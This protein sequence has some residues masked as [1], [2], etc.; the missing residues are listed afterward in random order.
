MAG[1]G[2]DLSLRMS[3]EEQ[4]IDG[5]LNYELIFSYFKRLKVKISHAIEKTFPFL[6]LLRDHEFITN[7]MFEDCETSCRNLV[8]INNV[9]YNVLDELEKKFNLEVLKIL[10]N[11][12]NIKEYPGLTPIYEIFLN[13]LPKK[14][15][16]Q[17]IDE[18]GREE[19]PS[20]Q[21]SLEQGSGENSFPSLPG[22]QSD[23]SFSTGTTPPES[24]LLEHLCETE[25]ANARRN[26]TTGDK[27][28]A[29]GGQQANQQC[30]PKP[31][32]AGS[33]LSSQG[34]QMNS[35]FV[36]LVNIMKEIPLFHSEDEQQAQARTNHNQASYTIGINCGDSGKP[37]D[38]HEPPGPSISALEGGHESSK[39]EKAQEATCSRPQTAPDTMD[40]GNNSALEEHNG[41]RKRK[42][43]IPG[44]LKRRSSR[45]GR[46]RGTSEKCIKRDNGR[47]FTLKR[48][49]IKGGY[50][51]SSKWKQNIRCGG[52]PLQDLIEKGY[53]QIPP[54]AEKK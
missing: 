47:W 11:E 41:K 14:W 21:L 10:F 46:R 44:P 24:G 27:N 39:R 40:A 12:D 15:Y 50:K 17:E 36:P 43:A 53:L 5:R 2:H 38:G 34:L 35:C 52:F 6:Q 7:E 45:R 28:D 48:F 1:G 22:P 18:E 54:K 51:N 19:G 9:V 49:E 26:D 23:S 25:Q 13:V 32:P 8:P 30:A 29:V 42:A 37:N 20:G 31:E 4:N 16:L 3:T 33:E